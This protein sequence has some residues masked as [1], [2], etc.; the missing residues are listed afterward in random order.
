MAKQ[1]RKRRYSYN[2][3]RLSVYVEKSVFEINF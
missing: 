1:D 3:Y 2:E